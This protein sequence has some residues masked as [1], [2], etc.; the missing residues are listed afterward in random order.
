MTSIN[1]IVFEFREL[2]D[3]TVVKDQWAT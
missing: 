2:S 1:N 3:A